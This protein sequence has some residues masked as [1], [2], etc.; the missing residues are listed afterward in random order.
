VRRTGRIRLA[1]DASATATCT[2]HCRQRLARARARHRLTG[3]S[4]AM[5]RTQLASASDAFQR[6]SREHICSPNAL[7]VLLTGRSQHPV[8]PLLHAT[9]L[10]LADVIMHRTMNSVGPASG[11]QPLRATGRTSANSAA[12]LFL[13]NTPDAGPASGAS[14]SSVQCTKTVKNTFKKSPNHLVHVC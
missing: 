6:G 13:H 3:R 10:H 12:A 5:H 11:T 7:G 14:E 9:R 1:S 2:N 8:Q 4:G